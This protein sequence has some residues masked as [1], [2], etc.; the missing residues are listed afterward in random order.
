MNKDY[1]SYAENGKLVLNNK[2]TTDYVRDENE[3]GE[4]QTPHN[5]EYFSKLKKPVQQ[6]E[7]GDIVVK[8]EYVLN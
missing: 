8:N 1:Y 4:R 6:L 2:G 5:A 3:C 7:N